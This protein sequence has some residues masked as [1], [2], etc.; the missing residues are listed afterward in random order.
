M[1]VRTIVLGEEPILRTPADTVVSCDER[2]SALLEDLA[3]TMTMAGGIGL[4]APQVGVSL[5]VAVVDLGDGLVELVNPV[6]VSESGS[7]MG[8]ESCLSFPGMALQINRPQRIMVSAAD[9][10]GEVRELEA[11][12]RLARAILHEIDHLNGIL[13]FDHVPEEDI[14]MQLWDQVTDMLDATAE[15]EDTMSDGE[16]TEASWES[17]S[18]EAET[19]ADWEVAESDS[20]W[21][22]DAQLA[23]DMMADAVWKLELAL[24]LL[25]DHDQV[26]TDESLQTRLR[27]LSELS[28]SLREAVDRLEAD[29]EVQ[30]A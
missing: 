22:Q 10:T 4:S 12:G 20:P 16:D 23:S 2:L 24:E 30:E 27:E 14:L 29:L 13:F 17:E 1:A 26:Q 7:Q 9:R 25:S 15:D 3:E 28:Q 11:E 5:R 6:V 18:D 21:V 19:A 8:V